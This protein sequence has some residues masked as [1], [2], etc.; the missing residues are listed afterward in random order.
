M[1]GRSAVFFSRFSQFQALVWAL[2]VAEA[3]QQGRIVD[4]TLPPR[5]PDQPGLPPSTSVCHHFLTLSQG[6]YQP[7][8]SSFAHV[9]PEP[10][11]G[12]TSVGWVPLLLCHLD[13]PQGWDVCLRVA[14]G[15]GWRGDSAPLADLY[16]CL[17]RQLTPPWDRGRA[18]VPPAMPLDDVNA[19]V[20]AAIAVVQQSQGDFS[21][22]LKT[23]LWRYGYPSPV[24]LWAALFSAGQRGLGTLPMAWRQAVANSPA[25]GIETPAIA[26]LLTAATQLW[27]LWAGMLPAPDASPRPVMCGKLP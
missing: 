9:P 23:A 26:D 12:F 10:W 5:S 27:R 3:V 8:P 22:T 13:D 4:R 18:A 21:L 25:P 2:A 15:L 11:D 16:Q 7:Q 24:C 6:L 19:M 17:Q 1:Q 20:A 14:P